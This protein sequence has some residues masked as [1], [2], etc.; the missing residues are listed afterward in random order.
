MSCKKAPVKATLKEMKKKEMSIQKHSPMHNQP[1]AH[2]KILPLC[3]ISVK[4]DEVTSIWVGQEP[5]RKRKEKSSLEERLET[6]E[7]CALS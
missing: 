1:Y 4:E 2:V 3:I 7:N 6:L 5:S